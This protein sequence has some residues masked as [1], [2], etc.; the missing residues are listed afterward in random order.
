[1]QARLLTHHA[2]LVEQATAPVVGRGDAEDER[3]GSTLNEV[4]CIELACGATVD[5]DALGIGGDVSSDEF[6]QLL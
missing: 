4:G 1:V 3:A 6:D 5:A 2:I